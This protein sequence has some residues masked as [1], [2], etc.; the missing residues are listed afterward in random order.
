MNLAE[1]LVFTDIKQLHQIAGYYRCEC[2]LNSKN[3]LITTLLVNLRHRQTIRTELERLTEVEKHFLLLLFLDKRSLFTL[4]DLLAK[5]GI[6]LDC[7]EEKT[8]EK[9]RKYVALALTRGW[10]FPAK[11][12]TVGQ[13][14]VPRDI[15][16]PYLS[17][18]LEQQELRR[19]QEAPAVY[20]DEGTALCDDI[21]QFL[22]FLAQEPVPL[23]S[24]GG[25]YKRYQTQLLRFLS[26]E[27]KPVA[28]EKWRFGYGLHF[29]LYPDR[30]S[31]LYD[32]CFYQR[33]IEEGKMQVELTD[34]GQE[35]LAQPY[36]DKTYHELIRFWIRLYKRAIPNLPMLVQLIPL[37]AGSEWVA[38]A[39]IEQSLLKWLKPFYYDDPA[40][41]L[42]NRLLKMMVH[43]GLLKAGQA[44]GGEWYYSTTYACQTWL[45]EYNGFTETTI[46]LK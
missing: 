8:E 31:L 41:I 5:A 32:F 30:F 16:E 38:H 24:D 39:E 3:D 13:F 9:A 36:T 40:S 14:Q 28:G 17:A 11:G 21:Y 45:K 44:E 2:N 46:L 10:L 22:R 33:W 29:D 35:M 6:A 27:E 19:L 12:K 15:R 18:W 4:E 7:S 23:T 34:R 25:M 1:I 37:M 42:S 43:L 20:R 26:V